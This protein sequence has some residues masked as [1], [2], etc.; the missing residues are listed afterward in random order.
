MAVFIISYDLRKPDYDYEPLYSALA[1]IIR[2]L[3]A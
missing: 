2:P 3:T 1:S